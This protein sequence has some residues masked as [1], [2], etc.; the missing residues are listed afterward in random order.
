MDEIAIKMLEYYGNILSK[1]DCEALALDVRDVMEK[2][3]E[4]RCG[5]REWLNGK[6][7]YVDYNVNG[8]QL[9]ALGRQL[10]AVH[11][12]IPVA[13]LL[14]YLEGMPD[15][16]DGFNPYR[17]LAAVASKSCFADT[18]VITDGLPCR[19]A[20][21]EADQWSFFLNTDHPLTMKRY[22]LWQ[23]LLLNPSL[24]IPTAIESEGKMA[25]VLRKDGGYDLLMNDAII[26]LE[27]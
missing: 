26:A 24:I 3:P 14:L 4:L 22:Q 1:D 25:A 8:F 5:V 20:I 16:E 15:S 18:C 7:H 2:I 13:A 23:I 17:G 6:T 27:G 11:P 9:E 12:N 21:F 19:M 10:D